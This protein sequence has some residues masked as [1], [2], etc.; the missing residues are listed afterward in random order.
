[1]LGQQSRRWGPVRASSAHILFLLRA[2]LAVVSVRDARSSADD[3]APLERAIIA[4]VANAHERARA[5]VGVADGALA[6]ALLTQPADG[7]SSRTGCNGSAWAQ[8]RVR[9]ERC[10]SHGRA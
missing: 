8:Q 9:P 5:H 3:T 7:C 10:L 6:I 4:L 2:L 1:M